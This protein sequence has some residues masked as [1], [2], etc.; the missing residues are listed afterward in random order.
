MPT[1]I[2]R[3]TT[4]TTAAFKNWSEHFVQQFHV[5]EFNFYKRSTWNTKIWL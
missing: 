5:T 2:K 3:K 1:A 4:I